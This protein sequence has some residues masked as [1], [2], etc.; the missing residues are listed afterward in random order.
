MYTHRSLL[1][2]STTFLYT[3]QYSTVFMYTC[4]V[5]IFIYVYTT[6]C[7]YVYTTVQ[8]GP[9]RQYTTAQALDVDPIKLY[10]F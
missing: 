10:T 6:D 8:D 1:H 7:N 9:T 5:Y 3:R 4:R 2:D